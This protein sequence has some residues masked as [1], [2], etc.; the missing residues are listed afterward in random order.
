MVLPRCG[1]RRVEH[2]AGHSWRREQQTPRTL[3]VV[4]HLLVGVCLL[5][6]HRSIDGARIAA[7]VGRLRGEESAED[8]CLP[9]IVF[10][11]AALERTGLH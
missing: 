3:D 2:R 10:L 8:E 11:S 6:Q 7:Q 5:G 1:S 4:V 9:V